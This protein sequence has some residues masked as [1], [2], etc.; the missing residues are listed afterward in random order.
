MDC[1]ECDELKN[2]LNSSARFKEL[3]EYFLMVNQEV[4]HF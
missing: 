4:L 3:S 1:S 2:Q